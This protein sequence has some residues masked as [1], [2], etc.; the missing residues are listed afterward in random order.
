MIDFQQNLQTEEH[1]LQETF[2]TS[3]HIPGLAMGI[4]TSKELT[5]I[6]VRLQNITVLD[7]KTPKVPPF[8][9]LAKV[10]L[11]AL[12]ASDV[13]VQ[14]ITVDLKSFEKV[15]DGSNLNIDEAM[16]FWEKKENNIDAPSQIHCFVSLIKS[17][18]PLRD[19][20]KIMTEV[21]NDSGFKETV[22][23]L[24]ALIRTGSNLTTVSGLVFQTAGI[25]GKFL[26]RVD[27]KP[28]LTWVQSFTNIHGDFDAVGE[29][30]KNANNKFATMD[31]AM[32][33]RDK[34]RQQAAV[35]AANG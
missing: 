24:G 22:S 20:S 27:D 3:R 1:D 8:P 18:Q 25:I 16:F 35:A 34:E 2:E 4:P 31:L 29:L 23:T 17:K 28:L 6:E 19:V 13:N 7:N 10:Y 5:G 26:G 33:V 12:A 9:G 21:Q 32:T 15:D 11:I 30:K 14:P